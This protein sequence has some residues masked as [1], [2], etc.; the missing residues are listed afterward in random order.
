[1]EKKLQ[2]PRVC[3]VL[4]I[5][6]WAFTSLRSLAKNLHSKFSSTISSEALRNIENREAQ[7]IDKGNIFDFIYE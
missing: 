3:A 1:M 4:E 2:I 6:L 7:F 5:M